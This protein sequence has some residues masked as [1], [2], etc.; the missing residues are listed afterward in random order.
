[1]QRHASSANGYTAECVG[2]VQEMLNTSINVVNAEAQLARIPE[3]L[4]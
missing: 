3:G 4:A 2:I 1:L